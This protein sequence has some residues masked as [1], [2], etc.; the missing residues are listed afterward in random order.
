VSQPE[1]PEHRTVSGGFFEALA[2]PLL[3]GRTFDRRDDQHAP[4]RA[5]VSANLARLA[6]PGMPFEKVVGQRFRLL[7]HRSREIIGVVGDVTIDVYGSPT[8]AV[9][10]AHRQFAANRNWALTQ[11]VATEGPPERILPDV[12]A[13]IASMD[14]ELAVFRPASMADIVGRGA[15][16]ER[17]A[18]VVIAS[19]A[20]VSLTLA[21]IGLYGVLAF[22]VRQRTHEIGIRIA[23]GATAAHIRL[24]V[25][26]QASGVLVTGL[27]VG[28]V[29]ALALGQW[30]TSLAF[31][32]SPTDPRIV[33]AA[34]VVLT[35]TALV[36]AWLPA[37]RAARIEPR[38]AIQEG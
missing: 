38:I 32:I 33:L 29:G 6:F 7:N 17:F 21:A 2:I 1:Q 4:M 3:A 26:R 34:A 28:T 5:V 24:S 37:R 36:A 12:R 9:Y 11:V 23:L 20:A 22:A 18:L 35:T 19:F 31:G 25:L 10:T 15:S 27:V 16:R 14:P 13:V 8:S 30:L